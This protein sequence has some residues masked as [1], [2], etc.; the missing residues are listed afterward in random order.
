MVQRR[1]DVVVVKVVQIKLRKEEYALSMVQR[2]N[3]VALC[4]KHGGLRSNQNYAA[5][6]VAQIISN[7]E[8]CVGDT[9]HIVTTPSCGGEAVAKV[10]VTL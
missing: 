9:V 8:E 10:D 2:S 6:K 3:D 4:I 1:N 7:E 5:L